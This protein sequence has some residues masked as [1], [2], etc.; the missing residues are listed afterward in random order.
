MW[1]KDPAAWLALESE[2]VTAKYYRPPPGAHNQK[3]ET[4]D[5]SSDSDDADSLKRAPVAKD[6]AH[7]HNDGNDLCMFYLPRL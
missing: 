2:R 3:R 7:L 1:L 4:S 6:S 5:S